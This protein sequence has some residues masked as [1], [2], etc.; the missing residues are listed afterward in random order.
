[1]LCYAEG[2]QEALG[3]SLLHP[4]RNEPLAFGTCHTMGRK[5]K[6]VVTWTALLK[7]QVSSVSET[8]L[9]TMAGGAA[10]LSREFFELLKAIGEAKSKQE[11]ERLVSEEVLRLR[12]ALAKPDSKE[13][14][15]ELLL[16]MI[17]C[18]MLGR[19]TEFG[20][21]HAL[22]MTQS[23]NLLE[24]RVGY[25]SVATFLDPDNPL[26]ILLVNSFRRVRFL[27]LYTAA[28]VSDWCRI[29]KA[30]TTSKSVLH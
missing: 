9:A 13:R 6:Q 3:F 16:R 28:L 5:Q 23:S 27:C 22:N 25:L 1:M 12:A 21:I 7:S 29:L 4:L 24:K 20:Y 30:L 10:G 14:M 19:D 15:K 2:G 17:Y 8:V 11:E 18:E 26:M